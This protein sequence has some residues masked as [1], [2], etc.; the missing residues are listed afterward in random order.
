MDTKKYKYKFNFFLT[1]E[2][3]DLFFTLKKI[4]R[5]NNEL[6]DDNIPFSV[7]MREMTN[8]YNDILLKN[9]K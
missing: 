2:E 8:F 7:F 9:K 3:K 6:G 5:L 1:D 4:H